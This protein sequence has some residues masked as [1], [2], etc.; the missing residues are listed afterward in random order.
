M[1]TKGSRKKLL[2]S[3]PT[4]KALSKIVRLKYVLISIGK[5]VTKKSYFSF[6]A[7]PLLLDGPPKKLPLFCGSP[8]AILFR[9]EFKLMLDELDWMDEKTR[10]RAHVKVYKHFS[11]YL[12]HVG[13][14]GLR[15]LTTYCNLHIYLFV[16]VVLS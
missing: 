11:L 6:V 13:P 10:E 14:T 7:L 1:V 8:K 16:S 2:F 15:Q 4:T 9:A 12:S 3:V 5:K